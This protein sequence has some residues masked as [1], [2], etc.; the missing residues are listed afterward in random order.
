MSFPINPAAPENAWASLQQRCSSLSEWGVK[1]L[2]EGLDGFVQSIVLEPLYIC[3]DHRNLHSNFY[4]K[5]FI[6]VTSMCSRLHFFSEPGIQPKDLLANEEQFRDDY[7]GYSVVRPVRGACLGRTV[8]DPYKIGKGIKDGYYLLR[9]PFTAQINGTVFDVH[10]YP[11][12]SQDGDATLCAHSALWGVCRYLSQRY[13]QYRELYP[14]DFIRMTESSEG[15]AVPY[16]GMTYTDYCRILGQFGTFP[17][18]RLVQ[19]P[20]PASA[21]ATLDADAFQDLYSYMESGFPVLAS[22]RLPAGGHVVSLIG[23]TLDPNKA[24]A[25]GLEFVDS[26]HFLKQ[27]VVADDNY[28]PYRTL[29]YEG[30]PENYAAVYDRGSAKASTTSIRTMTCPLPEKVFIPAEDARAKADGYCRKFS[31]ILKQTGRAPFVTRLFVTTSY[32]FK[33]RKLA[34][35][36]RGPD[37]AA[38]VPVG[39]HLPH[40]IWVM[41]VSP[42]ELF[43]HGLCTSEIV[44]DAT[45]GS[46][47]EGMIYVR[48]GNQVHFAPLKSMKWSK[49]EAAPSMYPQY[50]HN[51]G[52]L[53]AA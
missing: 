49:I 13:T 51:L 43:K 52:E 24:V 45:A 37:L 21:P 7:L 3:K 14:F 17:I 27:F 35:A 36:R 41:E 38:S 53:D 8:I 33:R 23:H 29:G 2:R 50:T 16:R 40:F 47:E 26:S 4:S 1:T 42:L 12:T 32:A 34:Q 30:D 46:A 9:T 5:K 19:K 39:M 22:L 28:F 20:G 31:S 48:I 11:W 18:A 25:S 10:G 15:R 44:L 6:E